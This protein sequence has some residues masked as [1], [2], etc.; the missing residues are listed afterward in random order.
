MHDITFRIL[1]LAMI[2]LGLSAKIVDVETAFL[3]GE[4]DEEIYMECP[5]GMKSKADEI[6]I[7][8]Q[9]IY[10]LVQSARQ[11]HEKAVEILR[12]N[13]FVGGEVDPCLFMK[14]SE[15]GL[16]Y[17]A[18]CVGDNLLVGHPEA[19]KH[20]IYELRENDLI[21]KI[22]DD[23]TGYLSCKIKFSD[24]R[25]SAW[26]GQPHLIANS[27]KSFGKRVK[28]MRSYA[29]P[30][31]P[32]KIMIREKDEAQLISKEDQKYSGVI[33]RPSRSSSLTK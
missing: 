13:G 26:L 17:I 1:I 19:I 23:L 12:K 25:K 28:G 7:L 22:D 29:T 4:L 15:K 33:S 27:K 21:L 10:G 20:V 31:T 5:P 14:K 2:L 16:V 32:G 24:N 18:L 11:D 3:Y 6:L 8:G 30:G 9:C